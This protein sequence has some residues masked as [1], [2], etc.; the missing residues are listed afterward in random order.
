MLGE[1][2]LTDERIPSDPDQR[3]AMVAFLTRTQW[4]LAGRPMPT[5]RRAEMPGQVIRPGR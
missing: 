3:L 1:E 2:S 5:Y 4:A